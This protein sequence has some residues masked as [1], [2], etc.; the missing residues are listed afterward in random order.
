M[1]RVILRT[2]PA[3]N[4][5]ESATERHF[6]TLPLSCKGH[7]M[8]SDD[9]EYYRKRAADELKMAEVAS[10][11]SVAAIHHQLAREYAAMVAHPERRP[12]LRIVF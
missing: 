2:L 4:L 3:I 12:T 5:S 1:R 11:A 9:T 10:D 8:S 7:D 6:S